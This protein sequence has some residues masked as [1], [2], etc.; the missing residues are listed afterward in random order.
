MEMNN[1]LTSGK[2][3]WEHDAAMEALAVPLGEAHAHGMVELQSGYM[4]ASGCKSVELE[5]T[6]L[7][8]REYKEQRKA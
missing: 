6:S 4:R 5:N 3:E 2:K 7:F 8:R 1:I